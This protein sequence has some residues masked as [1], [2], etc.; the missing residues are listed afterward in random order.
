[1][2]KG[3]PK[4]SIFHSFIIIRSHRCMRRTTKLSFKGYERCFILSHLVSLLILF[5]V[6]AFMLFSQWVALKLSI[7]YFKNNHKTEILLII[8][9]VCFVFTLFWCNFLSF[10]Y[11]RHL[12]NFL[13]E[14]DT[15]FYPFFGFGAS[16]LYSPSHCSFIFF[17]AKL[18]LTQMTKSCSNM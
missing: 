18:L 7:Q 14:W 6:H 4:G 9:F 17:K 15:V 5:G 2:T 13:P 11:N 16:F 10:D 12:R 3:V 1:M 8:M